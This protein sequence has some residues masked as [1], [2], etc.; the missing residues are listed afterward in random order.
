VGEDRRQ[1]RHLPSPARGP[2]LTLL[3]ARALA[4]LGERP[5]GVY[6][7]VP[8]CATRC[9]YCNFVT[10][11]AIELGGA[12]LQAGYADAAV[13]EIRLAARTL[14]AARPPAATVFL[15]GG[16]PTS[17][18][19]ADLIR[20]LRAVD[21]E[22][23]LVPGA[24]VTVEANPD[25]V[26]AAALAALRAGGF[27][28][29]SFGMQSVRGHVLDVLDRTHTPGRPVAAAR[30]ARAAGFEHINLDLIYGTPGETDDD[31]RATLDA[32]I[33]A[34]PDHVSAYA[35]TVEP[36]TKFGAR[37]RRGRIATPDDDV[38]AD[39]YAVA[40][41]TLGAAGYH[42]YEV[43]NWAASP[44]ARCAHNLLYWR[45]DHWWGVGPG[46][47]G[48]IGGV[49]WWNV[50]HPAAHAERVRAGSLPFE[51]FEVCTPDERALEDLLLGIRLA[52]GID[53]GRFAAPA[54]TDLVADGLVYDPAA[55]DGRLVL[56]RNG[57]LLTDRVIRG[58]VVDAPRAKR[59]SVAP[60]RA[61]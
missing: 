41:E 37:V 26:D 48:H 11:T 1:V 15:G 6:V 57:R 3:D 27:N 43:S 17:L 13:A 55:R 24:E 23:G 2:S 51:G 21:D 33:G 39:R 58:L 8:F 20:I 10:Y 45:N 59:V 32:A 4:E 40:D 38:M 49:R 29:I 61:P 30:E 12:R 56:T 18:P 42:W 31:W 47:H 28:R 14:G 50:P 34:G 9:G 22:L 44:T 35:L 53:A 54:V 60:L 16:T 5:F 25:S 36:R 46:A 52:A 19:P 7:H